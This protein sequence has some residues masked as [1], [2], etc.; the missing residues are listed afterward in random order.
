MHDYN[1]IENAVYLKCVPLC[2]ILSSSTTVCSSIPQCWH[3]TE[4]ER[5]FVGQLNFAYSERFINK[6]E[7]RLLVS[8]SDSTIYRLENAGLFPKRIQVTQC[9]VVWVYSEILEWMECK[10]QGR[11]WRADSRLRVAASA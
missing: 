4:K 9:R 10:R 3:Q 7:V 8:L 6:K 1:S 2:A 11:D 5:A